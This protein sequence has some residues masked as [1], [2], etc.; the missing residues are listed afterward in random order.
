MARS[1]HEQAND[2]QAICSSNEQIGDK[3]QFVLV[4]GELKPNNRRVLSL[5]ELK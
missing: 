5:N 1:F 4:Q 3:Q 2:K